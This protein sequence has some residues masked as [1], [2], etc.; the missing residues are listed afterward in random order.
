PLMCEIIRCHCGSEDEN[1]GDFM[2]QCEDCL[3]WQHGIC[4]GLGRIEDC[5]EHYYCELC[6]PEDRVALLRHL[7][8]GRELTLVWTEL[9]N[10]G[11]L[12]SQVC[13]EAN[14]CGL[15]YP[16]LSNLYIHGL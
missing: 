16:R 9:N 13:I 8:Q 7:N 10:S 15:V 2:I 4:M 3:A 11:C 6:R 14:F 1:V 5:P 12:L